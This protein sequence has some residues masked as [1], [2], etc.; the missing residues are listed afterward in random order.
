MEMTNLKQLTRAAKSNLPVTIRHA[1]WLESNSNAKYS[2]EA[3]E[4]AES[5]LSQE[6]GGSRKRNTKI[7]RASGTGSCKRRRI[8]ALLGV[9]EKKRQ[10]SGLSNIFHTGN[11]L[12][13]KWQ[14]AGISEGWLAQAE[15]PIE[16]KE[17]PLGGTVDGI[18][19]EGSG[20][21]FKTIYSFGFKGVMEKGPKKDHILQVHAYMAMSD[22]KRFS[23]V[24]ENKDNG[25]WREFGVEKDDEICNRVIDEISELQESIKQERLP[26]QIDS[27]KVREGS[28]FRNCP[29][30]DV[31]ATSEF[32]KQM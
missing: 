32:S 12:H 31:C 7:F 10:D 15:V 5:A 18:L 21:E 30:S 19:Y 11:F 14:M 29:Y 2:K 23:I 13:L 9:P 28:I 8:L 4:F 20:F 3:L 24:Y 1:A 27:C 16:S 25:E 26:E 17:M 6:V 22:I